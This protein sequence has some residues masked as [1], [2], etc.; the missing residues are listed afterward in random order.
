MEDHLN[1]INS[2]AN[3]GTLRQFALELTAR[4]SDDS[5]YEV[6]MSD[7]AVRV[8]RVEKE[9][10]FLGIGGHETKDTVLEVVK[11]DELTTVRPET[12]DAEFVT[13]LAGTLEQ[14]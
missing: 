11:E 12:A 9:G 4:L 8:Q 13:Y 7:N 10:G 1:E 2:W 6:E 5:Q 14:H 3:R